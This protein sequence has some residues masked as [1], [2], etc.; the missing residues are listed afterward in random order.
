MTDKYEQC[1]ADFLEVDA[2][3]LL[4]EDCEHWGLEVYE[5]Y[6]VGTD[7]EADKAAKEYIKETLWAFNDEFLAEMTGL[8]AVIFKALQPQCENSNDAVLALVDKTCGLEDFAQTA[9]DAD[10][11]GHFL[12]TYDGEEHEE[13]F[14]DEQGDRQILNFYRID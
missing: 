14:T 10:G 12:A 9:I 2:D 13:S 5:G 1:I 11:R 7:E 3:G 6:A 4:R 8:P